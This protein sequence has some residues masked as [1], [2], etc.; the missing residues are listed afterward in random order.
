MS[1]EFWNEIEVVFLEAAELSLVERAR[2]LDDRCRDRPELRAE[3][4]RLFANEDLAGDFLESA[5]W[6]DSEIMDSS[7]RR[8]ISNSPKVI[9][10][11][12][13][14][15]TGLILGPYRLVAEIGHGGM[16]SVY[17]GERVDGEFTQ[18]VAIKILKRGIDSQFVIRRFR[19]ERQILASFEHPFISRLID[20]GTTS[21]GIPYFVME[22]IREG[23][24]IYDWCDKRR[25]NIAARLKLFLKVCSALEY[26][27][28]RMIVHRDIKPGNILVNR[29]GAPK[30]L[31]F[32]IAKILDPDAIHD[33]VHPTA[34]VT[35]MMTPDYASPEQVRGLDITPA[36]DVYSLGVLLY[37]LVTGHR[38]Y[39][40][41]GRS[42]HELSHVISDVPPTVPSRAIGNTETLL[43]RYPSETSAMEA[44]GIS[45]PELSSVLYG[46]LDS[47]ILKALSKDPLDRFTTIREMSER[48]RVLVKDRQLPTVSA[49]SVAVSSRE[50]LP[51]TTALKSVAILPFKTIVLGA[52]TDTDE[53]FLGVGLADSLISRLGRIHRF[54]VTPTSS[55]LG[56]NDTAPDPIRAGRILNVDYVLDGSIRLAQERVRLSVQLLDVKENAAVWATSIDERTGDLLALEEAL[57]NQLI[58][59]LVPRL[60][61]G[62]L[63]TFFQRRTDSPEAFEFYLRGRYYF[64]GMTEEWL[65]EAFLLFHQAI[66]ADPDY[67]HAYCGIANYYN[68]LGVMGV[69]P[70]VECFRP[71]LEA[72]KKAVELDPNLSEAHASLG[73]SL[74]AGVFDW[75]NAEIH[76]KKA[77]ELNPNN[78]NA[79][80]W[81]STYL[82]TAGRFDEG[83]DHANRAIL[84][85]PLTPYTKYN[86]CSGLYYSGR[87]DEAEQQHRKVVEEFPD[88]GLGH[89]GLSKVHRIQGKTK[90]AIE[91]NDRA[92]EILDGSTLVQISAAECLAADGQRGDAAKK[93]QELKL[94]KE[95]RFVSPYLLAMVYT[96]LKDNSSVLELLEESLKAGEAWLCCTPFERR[97]GSLRRDQ[98]FR[99]LLKEIDHPFQKHLSQNLGE[100]GPTTRSFSDRTT[101]LIDQDS[102]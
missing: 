84:L 48:L 54:L 89:Y 47:I 77:V 64:S 78:A 20:G 30:L 91:E 4:D 36:S 13:P 102:N 23:V 29:S 37:E 83:F 8:A 40:L 53:Q 81:F 28:E 15:L 90:R 86:I 68:W 94:L 61:T 10:T 73:F 58:E 44:R 82:F 95:K 56:F 87:I 22:Y 21:D 70:P 67:A 42:L 35:R 6:S 43:K 41:G 98:R 72:A 26:A 25:L 9:K 79:H 19:H 17:L 69:L 97:F 92:F 57:S 101:I 39:T 52:G 1:P 50:I 75:R 85:D 62:E 96:F 63:A 99:S 55:V 74:H 3:V 14:D 60:S 80:L 24:N 76:F 65:A 12:E 7:I 11:E 33:S 31:D 27:H 51:G 66:A 32:G 34:S 18:Q 46:S 38:P 100:E 16:G 5:V 93:L 49:E 2:F 59:A 45:A 71:A 88:Y